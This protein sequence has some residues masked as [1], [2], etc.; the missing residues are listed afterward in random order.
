[1]LAPE[2]VSKC[3]TEALKK[4]T[5]KNI[6]RKNSKFTEEEL[7]IG[8]VMTEDDRFSEVIDGP[9][10]D[11]KSQPGMLYLK[12]TK[13]V[14][15]L[16][17]NTRTGAVDFELYPQVRD[18]IFRQLMAESIEESYTGE[19]STSMAIA[20]AQSAADAEL[21]CYLTAQIARTTCNL[22]TIKCDDEK[23]KQDGLD[24]DDI[25]EMI[26]ECQ[27]TRT[28]CYNAEQEADPDEDTPEI[29]IEAEKICTDPA[30]DACYEASRTC[31]IE[32]VTESLDI[33]AKRCNERVHAE[34]KRKCYADQ[35]SIVDA[36]PKEEEEEEEEG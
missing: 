19:L 31:E 3:E 27:D 28:Q 29:C 6:K 14:E 7:E 15:R 10:V 2:G 16:G 21:S 20:Y 34:V 8:M 5:E 11:G 13:E 25:A 12:S 22:D 4:E 23:S 1:M 33:T 36:A 17:R 9:E 18:A 30:V 32:S 26:V 35:T 24:D